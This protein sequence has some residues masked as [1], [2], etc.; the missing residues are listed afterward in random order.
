MEIE[1]RDDGGDEV[2]HATIT[3]HLSAKKPKNAAE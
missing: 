2:F 3:M 1:V